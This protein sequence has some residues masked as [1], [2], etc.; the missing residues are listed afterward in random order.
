MVL[1]AE[2]CAKAI[3]VS[4]TLRFVANHEGGFWGAQLGL[5]PPPENY[6]ALCF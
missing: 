1:T 5:E 4:P 3:S 6:K 2:K